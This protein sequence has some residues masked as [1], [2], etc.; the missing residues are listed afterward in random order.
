[1][2]DKA[3]RLRRLKLGDRLS[4]ASEGL[5][6]A[7]R[8]LALHFGASVSSIR[9]ISDRSGP[10]EKAPSSRDPLPSAICMWPLCQ[11]S[12]SRHFA[13]RSISPCGAKASQARPSADAYRCRPALALGRST[14]VSGSLPR[15]DRLVCLF[16]LHRFSPASQNSRAGKIIET[17]NIAKENGSFFGPRS[18]PRCSQE[19]RGTR[20]RQRRR[21]RR[22]A[23]SHRS[24]WYQLFQLMDT[25]QAKWKP[26]R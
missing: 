11:Q 7:A 24:F 9:R 17:D 12:L 21:R 23:R 6:L 8:R 20:Q 26:P 1:M 4:W 3:A 5:G 2:P 16:L 15:R 13:A 19:G 22:H 25:W 18:R 14:A 10:L